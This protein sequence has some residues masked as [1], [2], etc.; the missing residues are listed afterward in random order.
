MECQ[1]ELGRFTKQEEAELWDGLYLTAQEIEQVLDF[2][3]QH[4]TLPAVYPMFVMVAHTGARRSAI[5]R[6]EAM[7]FD[8]QAK[9]VRLRELKKVHG[10]RTIRIA[11]MS[12]RLCNVVSS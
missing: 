11:P 3:E 1:I 4:A 8:H 12:G 2:V 9:T 6:C 7:D 10:K 5:L